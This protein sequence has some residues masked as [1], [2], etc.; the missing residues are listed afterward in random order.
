[1]PT[2][3]LPWIPILS[4]KLRK[5]FMKAG[6]RAVFKSSAN[7]K[8]LLTSRNKTKL[9]SNSHPGVYLIECECEQKYIGETKM[10]IATKTKQYQKNIFEEKLEQSAIGHHKIKCLC[11]VKWDQVK[12]LKVESK[13]FEG[14]VREAIEI[15]FSKCGPK[16][17]NMNLDNGQYV[18]T[19]FWTPYFLYL[20]NI[21][22]AKLK[23]TLKK[24]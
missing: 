12:T 9:P 20:R 17:G 8:S 5:I 4:P 1:M 19:Q 15:Q 6:Y 11:S 7:L 23:R 2:I 14:N 13:K 3:S 10:K 21:K 16:N 24:P 22:E 18:K